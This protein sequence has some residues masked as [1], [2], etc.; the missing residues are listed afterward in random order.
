MSKVGAYNYH[1]KWQGQGARELDLQRDIVMIGI[2]Q[3]P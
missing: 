3:H 2:R 1:N